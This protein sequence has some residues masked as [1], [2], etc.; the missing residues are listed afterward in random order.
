MQHNDNLGDVV[1]GN[2]TFYRIVSYSRAT[3]RPSSCV[4]CSFAWVG[5]EAA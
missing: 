3:V 1:V 5:E 2:I 4:P